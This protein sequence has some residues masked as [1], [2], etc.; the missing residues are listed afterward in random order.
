M[1]N[2]CDD[3]ADCGQALSRNQ[4][5][6]YGGQ[7]FVGLREL[8][9]AVRVNGELRPV[10]GKEARLSAGSAGRDVAPAELHRLLGP[11]IRLERSA[12]GQAC[13]IAIDPGHLRTDVARLLKLK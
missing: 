4:L 7:V 5:P 11:S 2:R 3:L 10:A 6:L 13:V 1:G 9:A 8:Q 12:S